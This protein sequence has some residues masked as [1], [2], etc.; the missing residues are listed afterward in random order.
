MHSTFS[1]LLPIISFFVE[2]YRQ[3]II[4]KRCCQRG[5]LYKEE[6]L[7]TVVVNVTDNQACASV[8]RISNNCV[9]NKDT[10]KD[11]AKI[12]RDRFRDR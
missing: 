4:K 2:N 9:R 6:S 12:F 1:M 7:L 5:N 8:F 3:E 10:R 11:C